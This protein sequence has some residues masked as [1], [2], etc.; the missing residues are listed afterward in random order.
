MTIDTQYLTLGLIEKHY[1]QLYQTNQNLDFKRSEHQFLYRID[2]YFLPI[3]WS[4]TWI[5]NNLLLYILYMCPYIQEVH[6]FVEGFLLSFD[7]HCSPWWSVRGVSATVLGNSGCLLIHP[8]PPFRLPPGGAHVE[9]ALT[10]C[11]R[12]SPLVVTIRSTLLSQR[13]DTNYRQR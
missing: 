6:W 3:M 10:P 2:L 12:H 7:V 13:M 1:I 5:P 4:G 9:P 11:P 8:P